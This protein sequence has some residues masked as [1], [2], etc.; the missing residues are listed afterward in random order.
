MIERVQKCAQRPAAQ[1]R[2]KEKPVLPACIDLSSNAPQ[3]DMAEQ[4]PQQPSAVL[5]RVQPDATPSRSAAQQAG[6]QWQCGSDGN[7]SPQW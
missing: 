2:M 5:C 1:V 7:Q 3:Q 4:S 6:A